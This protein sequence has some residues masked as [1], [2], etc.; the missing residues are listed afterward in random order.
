[1]WWVPPRSVLGRAAAGQEGV[2]RSSDLRVL[3]YTSDFRDLL[4]GTSGAGSMAPVLAILVAVVVV[5]LVMAFNTWRAKRAAPAVPAPEGSLL[6]EGDRVFVSG[7]YYPEPTWLAGGA[8]YSGTLERFIPGQSESPAAVVRT[9]TPVTGNKLTGDVLV[10]QLRY[11]RATWHSGAVCNIEL[12]N[13][14][15]EPKP[16]HERRHGEWVESHAGIRHLA[17][18]DAV[19]EME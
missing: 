17:Q 7:S 9:D 18:G 12:C 1:M 16:W 2:S 5:V 8:G 3:G 11:R 6:R 4:G 13:F 19:L 14:E 10:M 15:P